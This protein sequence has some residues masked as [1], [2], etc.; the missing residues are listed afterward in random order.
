MTMKLRAMVERRTCKEYP[1][2]QICAFAIVARKETA[3]MHV[4]R[5]ESSIYIHQDFQISWSLFFGSDSREPVSPQYSFSLWILNTNDLFSYPKCVTKT[6][7]TPIFRKMSITTSI[8]VFCVTQIGAKSTNLK[9]LIQLFSALVWEPRVNFTSVLSLANPFC[10]Y[11]S[12]VNRFLFEIFY[13]FK[14]SVT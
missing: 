3:V 11:W 13:F 4:S 9:S 2:I 14:F 6:M 8:G 10:R 7:L 5:T 12:F 1:R